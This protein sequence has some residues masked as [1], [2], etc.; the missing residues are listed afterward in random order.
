[1]NLIIIIYYLVIYDIFCFLSL[2]LIHLAVDCRLSATVI[3]M[4]LLCMNVYV[5]LCMCCYALIRLLS[6]FF[7]ILLLLL[8]LFVLCLRQRQ[9]REKRIN[10]LGGN[11]ILI[12]F[13]CLWFLTNNI[14]GTKN[15]TRREARWK[16]TKKKNAA[17]FFSSFL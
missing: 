11:S 9:K 4:L 16:G 10:Y 5:C 12:Y 13:F 8:Y 7:G 3:T 1:M 2:L 14:N 17:V 6:L 15:I